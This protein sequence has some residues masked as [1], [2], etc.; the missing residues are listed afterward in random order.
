MN[1]PCSALLFVVMS[2]FGVF[3]PTS[4]N[5]VILPHDYTL[6]EEYI[7]RES[8]RKQLSFG[9]SNSSVPY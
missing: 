8:S 7:Y 4:P 1:A 2:Y 3:P 6:E 5:F 9:V